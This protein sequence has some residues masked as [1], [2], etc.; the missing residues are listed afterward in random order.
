MRFF[1]NVDISE[2]LDFFKHCGLFHLFQLPLL[3]VVQYLQYD[4]GVQNDLY[5]SAQYELEGLILL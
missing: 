3:V 1:E 2:L 5:D 4:N